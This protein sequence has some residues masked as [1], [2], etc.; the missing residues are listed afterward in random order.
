M[1]SVR[2]VRRD[3]LPAR[4]PNAICDECGRRGTSARITRYVTP[5]EVRRFCLRCWPHVHREAIE[6]RNAQMAAW[7]RPATIPDY[8]DP[9]SWIAS[10]RS[11]VAPGESATW[12]WLAAPGTLWRYFR[13][14]R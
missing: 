14:Q 8:V 1:P 9:A 7:L 2:I 13:H 4:E 12:H 6:R 11:R 10:V 3:A 5:P